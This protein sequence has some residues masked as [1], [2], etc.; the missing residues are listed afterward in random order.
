MDDFDNDGLGYLFLILVGFSI[1][2]IAFIISYYN[3]SRF[4]RCYDNNFVFNY[5]SKYKNY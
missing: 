3:L 5:C 4:K 1:I 2:M